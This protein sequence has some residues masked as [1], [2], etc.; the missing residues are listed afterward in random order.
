[1]W[2]T[3][4]HLNLVG[5]PLLYR[6]VDLILAVNRFQFEVR[7][8]I[9]SIGGP[10]W[11][12]ESEE[13]GLW[14]TNFNGVTIGPHYTLLCGRGFVTGGGRS[15]PINCALYF[16]GHLLLQSADTLEG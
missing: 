15:L 10:L 12:V 14:R 5:A 1:M 11:T 4:T 8:H 7:I 16:A 6:V 2:G 9:L 13:N 3:L